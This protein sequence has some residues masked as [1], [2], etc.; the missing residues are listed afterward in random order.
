MDVKTIAPALTTVGTTTLTSSLD[1]T[2]MAYA[3]AAWAAYGSVGVSGSATITGGNPSITYAMDALAQYAEWMTISSRG[4]NGQT[5]YLSEAVTINASTWGNG[6]ANIVLLKPDGTIGGT[7]TQLNR[8]T[9]VNLGKVAFTYGTPY[10]VGFKF[11][12]T[13]GGTGVSSYA[14]GGNY[15]DTAT[16]TG[17]IV[18][19]QMDFSDPNATFVGGSGTQYFSER[20]GAGAVHFLPAAWWNLRRSGGP[21]LPALNAAVAASSEAELIYPKAGIIIVGEPLAGKSACTASQDQQFAPLA[22]NSLVGT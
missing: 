3:G 20:R 18:T 21:A 7:A 14:G 8:S 12:V 19:T 17:L 9:T 22:A 11:F 5:G 13:V 16:L 10:Y 1:A 6:Q 15:A 4:L 2:H